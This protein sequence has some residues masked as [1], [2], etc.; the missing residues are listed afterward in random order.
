M[1]VPSV[2]KSLITKNNLKGH[3]KPTLCDFNV[4]KFDEIIFLTSIFFQKVQ[5]FPPIYAQNDLKAC[6]SRQ[7]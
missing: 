7:N 5:L 1:P 6:P 4:Q 3:E 2:T